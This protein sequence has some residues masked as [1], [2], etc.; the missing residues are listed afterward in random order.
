MRGT[1]NM[2][3]IQ[4]VKARTAMTKE[5]FNRNKRLLCSKLVLE[6]N[7]RDAKHI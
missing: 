7:K 4:K 3:C 6:L 5:A 1:N 2:E